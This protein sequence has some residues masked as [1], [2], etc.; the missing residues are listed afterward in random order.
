MSYVVH[1]WQSP[2]PRDANSA[3]NVI[4]ELV[5]ERDRN[6]D[7]LPILREFITRI[8][9]RYP[10]FMD[11]SDGEID[12]KGVWTDG[13]I[14]PSGA[15]EIIGIRTQFVD[16]VQPFVVQEANLLGLVCYDMQIGRLYL[17]AAS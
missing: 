14:E 4:C 11:L 3:W 1:V 13:P 2:V 12:E 5:A 15:I 10:D 16:E 6:P 7:A 8:T 9:G 17:P